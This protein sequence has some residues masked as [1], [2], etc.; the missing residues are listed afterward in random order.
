[1][2]RFFIIGITTL[3]LVT[4][5]CASA[6]ERKPPEIDVD[7]PVDWTVEEAEQLPVEADTTKWWEYFESTE[8]DTLVDEALLNNFD[9]KGAAARVDAAAAVAK[10]AG[11]DLFPQAAVR[12]DGGR[13]KQNLIGFPIPGSGGGVVSTY[14]TS[15]GVSLDIGWEIDLWGRIRSGQSAALADVQATWAELAGARLSVAAQTAKSWFAVTESRLQLE[16][17]EQTVESWRLS[18]DQVQRR[19]EEGV[20][21]SLDLRLALA[22]LYAAEAL[23]E[24]RKQQFDQTKRQMEI[25]LGRYPSASLAAAD[26]LPAIEGQVP[27]GL[28]SDLLIR[29]PDLLAAERRYAGAEKRVSQAR[30]AFFPRISLTGSGGTLTKQLADLVDGNFSVW[31]IAANITQPIFQ[32][33]RLKAN[34]ESSHAISDQILA[35]YAVSLLT[36]FGE[37]EALLYAEQT[38]ATQEM[39][40]ANAAEQSEAARLLAERQYNVGIVDYITVLETQRRAL[41]SQSELLT[42]RRQRLDARVNLHVSLGGG[43]DLHDEWLRFLDASAPEETVEAKTMEAPVE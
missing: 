16:L 3:V 30:R 18:A 31:S 21:T 20:R 29:R 35:Q 32:G 40:T 6:P 36:A 14:S 9:L 27:P 19:Y 8:L 37:V 34:L 12:F 43:F 4:A 42:V 23:Y 22:N 7:V 38:L 41:S 5:G 25:L 28:P 11:A 15:Y 13:R 17:A 24:F 10:A 26:D 2:T 33:G 1:M 39:H